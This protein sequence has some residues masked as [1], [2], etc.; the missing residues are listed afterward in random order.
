MGEWL[1]KIGATWGVVFAL[2]ALLILAAGR[3]RWM[4]WPAKRSR[5]NREEL[6]IEEFRRTVDELLIELESASIAIESRISAQFDR[7]KEFERCVDEKLLRF[8]LIG[9]PSSPGVESLDR[10][11]TVEVTPPKERA[12]PIGAANEMR[13]AIPLGPSL[14]KRERFSRRPGRFV[15][16][17]SD[18]GP[19]VQLARIQQMAEDGSSPAAIAEKLHVPL[20]EVETYLSIRQFA[21]LQSSNPLRQI[22]K[23]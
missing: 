15:K 19:S 23:S 14:G 8:K 3:A 22:D 4:K 20:G 7:L 6:H 1:A 21:R 18:A 10:A 11:A 2:L 5:V 13:P 12:G 17:G 16:A 9:A